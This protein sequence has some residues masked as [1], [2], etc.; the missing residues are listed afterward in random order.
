MTWRDSGALGIVEAL[1]TYIVVF[2]SVCFHTKLNVL[3][4]SYKARTCVF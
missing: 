4:L 2:I 3:V 1:G